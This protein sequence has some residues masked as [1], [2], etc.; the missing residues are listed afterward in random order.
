MSTSDPLNLEFTTFPK[1]VPGWDFFSF[2]FL[3]QSGSNKILFRDFL[4]D[5]KIAHFL[6][7]MMDIEQLSGQITLYSIVYYALPSHLFLLDHQ[8]SFDHNCLFQS[9]QCNIR[10]IMGFLLNILALFLSLG[11]LLLRQYSACDFTV[12]KAQPYFLDLISSK[13][14]V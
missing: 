8:M 3:P 5:L 2:S 7:H 11:V 1:P 12:I 6:Q 14:Q 4:L 9:S 13:R 10:E